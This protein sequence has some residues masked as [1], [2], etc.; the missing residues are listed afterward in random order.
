MQAGHGEVEPKKQFGFRF[1]RESKL[2][3][4]DKVMGKVLAIFEPF[5][6]QKSDSK[7]DGCSQ[8]ADKRSITAFLRRVHRQRHRQTARQQHRR[9]DRAIEKV[10][11]VTR[12]GKGLRI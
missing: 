6:E 10:R 9:V 8:A 12:F 2:S 5:H 3:A 4:W 1:G 7:D 11:M